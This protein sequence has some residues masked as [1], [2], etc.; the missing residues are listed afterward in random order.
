L[1]DPQITKTYSVC[2]KLASVQNK[3]TSMKASLATTE[4]MDK[5]VKV[6]VGTTLAPS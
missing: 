6:I 5:V 2:A 4:G 1:H 3:L